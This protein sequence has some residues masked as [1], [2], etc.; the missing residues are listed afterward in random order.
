LASVTSF[1][2]GHHNGREWFKKWLSFV[3]LLSTQKDSDLTPPMYTQTDFSQLPQFVFTFRGLF[4]L[5]V[6]A[7]AAPVAVAMR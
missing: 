2:I 7:G 5:V 6:M 3:F 1:R 4:L